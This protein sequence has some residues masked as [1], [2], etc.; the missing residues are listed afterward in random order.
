MIKFRSGFK[1]GILIKTPFLLNRLNC[2]TFYSVKFDITVSIRDDTDAGSA[3]KQYVKIIG[4]DGDTPEMEC[5]ANFDV[6]NQDVTCTVTATVY[7]GNYQCVEWRNNG[8]DSL[9]I[10]KVN[11]IHF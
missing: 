10:T 5:T 7:I 3:D 6:V 1:F 4:V 11:T 9:K 8:E 2:E